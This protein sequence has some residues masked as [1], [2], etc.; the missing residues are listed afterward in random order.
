MNQKKTNDIMKNQK[1]EPLTLQGLLPHIDR[2]YWPN[3]ASPDANLDGMLA[4]VLNI[5]NGDKKSYYGLDDFKTD[6]QMLSMDDWLIRRI[7]DAEG[8]KTYPA[9]S[10]KICSNGDSVLAYDDEMNLNIKQ[11]GK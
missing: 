1:N 8:W 2:A 5:A 10:M 4:D 11:T 6:I 7:A 9:N 3:P